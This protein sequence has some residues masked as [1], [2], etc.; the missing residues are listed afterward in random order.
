M[1]QLR[2]QARERLG[3]GEARDREAYEQVKDVFEAVHEALG[4][5]PPYYPQ[6][7]GPEE[8][9]EVP[10]PLVWESHR[11]RTGALLVWFKRRILF[12]LNRW[13]RK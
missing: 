5:G 7:L 8:D 11:G 10:T 4:P 9:W 6:A 1:S 12:P 13:L 2:L 3:F